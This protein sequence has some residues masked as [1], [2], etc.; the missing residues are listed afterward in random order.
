M[1]RA[2][3]DAARQQRLQE[4]EARLETYRQERQQARTQAPAERKTATM[5]ASERLR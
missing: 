3:H 5:Q 1:N 4:R 2:E